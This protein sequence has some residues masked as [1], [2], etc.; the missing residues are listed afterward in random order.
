MPCL[1][2]K[3]RADRVHVSIIKDKKLIYDAKRKIGRA[4]DRTWVA[5]NFEAYQNPE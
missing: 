3:A 4:R 5:G 1:N 2:R